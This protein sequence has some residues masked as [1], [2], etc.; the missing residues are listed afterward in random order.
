MKTNNKP[1]T[2][3]KL[4]FFKFA[5]MFSCL[6][7]IT[8]CEKEL[9]DDAIKDAQRELKSEIV[10]GKNAENIIS[11]LENS[12]KKKYKINGSGTNRITMDSIGT[13]K[14]DEIVKLTDE[15]GNSTYTFKVV[16]YD[17]SF[18]KFYNLVLQE[19]AE[20]NIVKLFEYTMTPEFAQQFSSTFNYKNFEGTLSTLTVINETPCPD[21]DILLVQVG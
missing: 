19:K 6:F 14:Y 13:I 5:F 9:Y 18:S 12:I 11:K 21:N 8:S 15:K 16:R 2:N 20:G 1:T 4:R 10:T 3:N 7:I 17:S